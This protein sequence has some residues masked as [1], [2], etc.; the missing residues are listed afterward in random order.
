MECRATQ[1][2]WVIMESSDKMRSTDEINGKALQYSCL[3]NPMNRMESPKNK[4]LKDECPR[5][6]GAQYA[7]REVG[8]MNPERM[9]RQSQSKNNTRLWM[10]LVIEV[11]SD[12]IKNNIA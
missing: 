7:T 8:E 3:E 12:A 5:S 11:K 2:G 6:V 4:T 1:N 9:K 10:S